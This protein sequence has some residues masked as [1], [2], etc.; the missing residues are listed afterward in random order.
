MP[1]FALLKP[2]LCCTRFAPSSASLH[3]LYLPCHHFPF[4]VRLSQQPAPAATPT[5]CSRQSSELHPL[6]SVPRCVPKHHEQDPSI[7]FDFSPPEL[8]LRSSS[9]MLAKNDVTRSSPPHRACCAAYG[10]HHQCASACPSLL[11]PLRY[12]PLA[13]LVLMLS[14]VLPLFHPNATA[15]SPSPSRPLCTAA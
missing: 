5:P 14:L 1:R 15:L 4:R 8:A 6:P 11:R 2:R 3:H 7:N 12:V 13:L 9:P 10:S